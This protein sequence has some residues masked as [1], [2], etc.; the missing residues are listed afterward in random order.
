MFLRRSLV[1]LLWTSRWS[2]RPPCRSGYYFIPLVV[3]ST[4]CIEDIS[5]Y[6]SLRHFYLF[7]PAFS[8]LILF[9]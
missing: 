1:L 5:Y 7:I 9:M 2:P 8:L 3:R 4:L 6:M